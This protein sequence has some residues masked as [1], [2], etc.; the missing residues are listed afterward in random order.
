MS[1]ANN[2]RIKRADTE[3]NALKKNSSSRPKSRLSAN[4]TTLHI[5]TK[6]VVC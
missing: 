4:L 1:M 2:Q 5:V 3:E 6:R